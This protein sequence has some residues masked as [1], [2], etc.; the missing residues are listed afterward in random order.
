MDGR[1][2]E[3]R[4]H[5]AAIASGLSEGVNLLYI[6]TG[7]ATDISGNL[8]K[9]VPGATV[10]ADNQSRIFRSCARIE[11]AERIAANIAA[12]ISSG[13]PPL[14]EYHRTDHLSFNYSYMIYLHGRVA[15]DKLTPPESVMLAS[16][17]IGAALH[18]EM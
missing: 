6:A 11:T 7:M 5:E 14:V 13:L 16:E 10:L 15:H 8:N 9:S 4:T 1:P 2:A 17:L 12:V 3:F 18:L